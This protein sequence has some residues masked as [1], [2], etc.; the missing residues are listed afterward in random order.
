ME[1][2]GPFPSVSAPEPPLPCRVGVPAPR[3]PSPPSLA[4]CFRLRYS[5][6]DT[7]GGNTAMGQGTQSTRTR[8]GTAPHTVQKH[9]LG[10]Q[11]KLEK[12]IGI[13]NSWWICKC[14]RKELSGANS[15]CHDHPPFTFYDQYSSR[16][17][18]LI[19][20]SNHLDFHITSGDGYSNN[21]LL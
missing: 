17:I 3:P 5:S 18:Q 7:W 8:A 21:K 4:S 12:H 13:I 9:L 6:S 16:N 15:D 14:S 11:V 20:F 2:E 10:L 19:C 1:P